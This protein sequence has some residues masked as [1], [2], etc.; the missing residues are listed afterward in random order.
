ME[1]FN[2]LFNFVIF[3]SRLFNIDESHSLKHSMDVFYLS[4]KIYESE[5]GNSSYLINHKNIIDT[6][7]ILHDMCDKKYMD[8]KEGIKRITNYLDGKLPQKDI[9][10][11]IKIMSTMSYSTIKK[12]GFPDLGEYQ[13][14]YNI[15]READLLASYDFD[16]CIMYQM[17]KN[18]EPYDRSFNDAL[19]I[20]DN[21]VFKYNDDKL[22]T[23]KYAQN[24]SKNL[25]NKALKRISSLNKILNIKKIY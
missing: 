21:R 11:S 18:N 9:D 25:H 3:T 20:F 6:V 14:A 7:S 5:L 10:L 17:L 19:N 22:F 8:E 15:V 4:N 23:T 1:L 24:L 12:Y 16:R 2:Y 13:L